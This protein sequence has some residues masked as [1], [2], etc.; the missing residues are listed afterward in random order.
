M[1]STRHSLRRLACGAILLALPLAVSHCARNQSPAT[2]M[3]SEKL[4]KLQDLNDH[5]AHQKPTRTLPDQL[6]DDRLEAL[7]NLALENRNFEDS[8]INYLQVLR[9]HPERYD[10]H[11]K[12]GVIFLMSGKLEAAQKELALVLVHR[13]EM[14]QAHEALGLVFLQGKQY[15]LAIDEFHYVLAQDPSRARTHHLLGVTFLEAGQIDRAI[16]EFQKATILDP[17]H[18]SSFILLSEA[19][20]KR[21]DY[22]H[23]T[24]TLRKAQSLA[25]DNQKVNRL[26]GQ[27]LS[28]QKQYPQALTAFLKA[29]DEAQAYNNIGVYYFM[30]GRYEEAA[31]CFQRAIELRP[32]FYQEAKANLQRAL[33]KLQ[34]SRQDDG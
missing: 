32:I 28:G 11:Y 25:P 7:G 34:E 15:P 5:W 2:Q 24:A 4:S 16:P 20:L 19:Y 18:L 30:D 8:L 17:R 29:G 6:P 9:D 13:P 3:D 12:V 33:E 26:L 21:K 22:T 23:A 27:A 14:L 31:K 1:K 10:L